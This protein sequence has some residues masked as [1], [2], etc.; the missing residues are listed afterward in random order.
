[1][2]TES[3]MQDDV[4]KSN[5]SITAVAFEHT[6]HYF[7]KIILQKTSETQETMFL[8]STFLPSA[9]DE[10]IRCKVQGACFFC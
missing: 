5:L 1:M 3:E 4:A 7:L 8:S 9:C 2:N 10:W 6:F